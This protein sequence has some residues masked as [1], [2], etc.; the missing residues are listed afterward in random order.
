MSCSE[1][2]SLLILAFLVC[3]AGI[4]SGMEYEDPFDVA[5]LTLGLLSLDITHLKILVTSGTPK[6]QKH[7]KKILPIVKR[8]HYL[9]VTLLFCNAIA[10]EAMPIFLDDLVKYVRCWMLFLWNSRWAAIFISVGLIL[11]V[12]EILPQSLCSRYGV[13]GFCDRW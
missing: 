5:G 12:G 8:H 7:A 10:A 2:E 3:F 11:F 9:L 6:E 4:C 13:C 1:M